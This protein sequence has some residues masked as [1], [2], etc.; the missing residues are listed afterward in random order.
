MIPNQFDY[1]RAQSVDEALSLLASHGGE[2]KLLAGGMS[3]LPLM[4]LRLASPAAVIDVRGLPEL[5][6]LTEADGVLR[7][8][9]GV[10]HRD[11]ERSEL[12][13]RAAPLLATAAATIGDAQVRARGTIGGSLAHAD[14]AADLPAVMLALEATLILRG[15]GGTREVAAGDFFLD[16]WET[17][18]APGELV[19]EVRVPSTE[20]RPHGFIKFRQRSQDWAIV[21][22]AVVGGG[23]PRVALVNMGM[24]PLRAGAVEAALAAGAPP[25]EAAAHAD[26]GT[27]PVSD[28]HAD[29]GYRRHLSRVLVRRALEAAAA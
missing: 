12:V 24:T 1:L 26:E 14:P 5:T 7:I 17:A 19:T 10:R 8:G 4:K 29:A 15:P 23:E 22:A 6:G 13:R 21:G 11:L 18:L 2:A 28:L 3:L 16:L 25:A 27:S 9:A 20:G